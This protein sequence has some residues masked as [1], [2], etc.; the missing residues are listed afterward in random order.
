MCWCLGKLRGWIVCKICWDT[1]GVRIVGAFLQAQSSMLTQTSVHCF[2]LS[3]VLNNENSPDRFNSR[4][5]NRDHPDIILTRFF[6]FTFFYFLFS[7]LFQFNLKASFCHPNDV[8][9]LFIT[10]HQSELPPDL[11]YM[12]CSK[13]IQQHSHL[14]LLLWK[15][16]GENI[17][18]A[19]DV[20]TWVYGRNACWVYGSQC[21][22]GVWGAMQGAQGCSPVPSSPSQRTEHLICLALSSLFLYSLLLIFQ[23]G[24]LLS[25]FATARSLYF[26][27][28]LIYLTRIWK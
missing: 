20:H 2:C 25:C 3:L 1:G 27:C 19:L 8:N 26:F 12:I 11:A 22:L 16:A 6:T 5:A 14:Q 17:C 21:M 7:I 18:F 9:R 24:N 4:S 28:H 13:K 10:N 23:L 15:V